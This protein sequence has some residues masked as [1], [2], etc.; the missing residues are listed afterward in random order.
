[1]INSEP[2]QASSEG[3]SMTACKCTNLASQASA[4]KIKLVYCLV[5]LVSFLGGI[6]IYAFFRDVGDMV[7]FRY[8]SPPM[9]LGATQVGLGTDTIWRYLFVFNLPHGL[10]ALS[11]LLV[12]RAVWLADTKW[13]A[14]YGGIF[15]VAASSIEIS[16]MSENMPGTFDVLDIASYGVSAFLE[17]MTYNK[18]IKRRVL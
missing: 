4:V 11:A 9:F 17:S 14:I 3:L 8:M 12:I 6:A 18:F 15:I 1:M 5:A 2:P 7:L 13:R 10:W 16:Q